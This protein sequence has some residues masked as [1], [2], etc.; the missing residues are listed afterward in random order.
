M[1]HISDTHNQ[2]YPDIPE[3][4]IC[5]HTGDFTN[6]GGAN[7]VREFVR[8]FAK[9]PHQWKV[10]IPG[11][12]ENGFDQRNPKDIGAQLGPG[13]IYLQDQ[14]VELMGVR[15]FGTS[16]S[17][18]GPAFYYPDGQGAVELWN[19]IIPESVDVLLTHV[20][21]LGIKDLAWNTRTKHRGVCGVCGQ[22]HRNY[23]HWGSPGL[24]TFIK[25]TGVP[26]HCFGHVHD[27]VGFHEEDGTLFS[28][29]AIDLAHQAGVLDLWLPQNDSSEEVPT[30]PPPDHVQ[31]TWFALQSTSSRLV[32]DVDRALAKPGALVHLWRR[33]GQHSRHR[34]S[35]G[36]WTRKAGRCTQ[37]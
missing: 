27:E 14:S 23:E 3:G 16:Y 35:C 9:L 13:V 10:I 31:D 29:A 20:P 19:R 1:V 25:R 26:V 37:G 5:V 6:N 18:C 12:H 28:N 11:N 15:F 22:E 21:P 30:A 32:L 24:L 4:D 2:S 17:N 7:E 8:W 33:L 36:G 34:S